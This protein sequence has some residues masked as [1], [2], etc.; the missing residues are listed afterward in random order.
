MRY[1]NKKDKVEFWEEHHSANRCEGHIVGKT[2]DYI[3]VKITNYQ[4]CNRMVF[5]ALGAYVKMF[6]QDLVN[7]LKMGRELMEI[8]VKKRM[9]IGGKLF[10]KQKE[11]DIYMEKVKAVNDRYALLRS[12]LEAEWRDE[13]SNLEDNRMNIL[14]EY[15]DLKMVVNEADAKMETYRV[16]DQNFKVDRWALDS[17]LYYKK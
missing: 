14:K 6:S 4:D 7:N 5:L 2:N 16:D 12:K 3:L 10:R 11:L 9:A 13:L 15:N 8:L 17:R 1:L